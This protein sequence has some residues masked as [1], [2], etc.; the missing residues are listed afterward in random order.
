MSPISRILVVAFTALALLTGVAS[1]QSQL[2]KKKVAIATAS[3]GLP[4]LPL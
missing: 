3:L 1:A 4:Y 2:E